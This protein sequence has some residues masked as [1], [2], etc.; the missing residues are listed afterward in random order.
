[1]LNVIKDSIRVIILSIV[2]LFS[3]Y[4]VMAAWSEPTVAPTGGN[5]SAP[6]DVSSTGQTKAG[7]L[8][9]NTGGA[10]NGLIISAGKVGIGT[11]SP[12]QA[13]SVDGTIYSGTGGVK[14]PDGTTQTSAASVVPTGSVIAYG[15]TTAPSGWLLANGAAVSRTTYATLFSIIGTSFGTGDGS[16]TFNVPDLRGEFIRGWNNASG[17]DPDAASRTA[18]MTGGASGDNI[19][20][21]QADIF[22]T[23]DHWYYSPSTGANA[24][25]GASSGSW[26]G[27]SYTSGPN[28]AGGNETRP[29]NVY[30]NYIIKY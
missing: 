3:A 25:Q 1:M 20:S 26:G 6:L 22:K 11:T 17:N 21:Y 23:H 15:A 5:I 13:L 24:G 2:V 10:T 9:L 29:K 18:F 28:P 14:F 16:T 19:G 7:G 27:G 4:V 30:L 12:S 8:I